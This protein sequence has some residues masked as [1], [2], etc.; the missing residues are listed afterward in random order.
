M[1]TMRFYLF[2]P[3]VFPLALLGAVGVEVGIKLVTIY[4]LL[5]KK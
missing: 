2:A 3:I 4:R 1:K 5:L